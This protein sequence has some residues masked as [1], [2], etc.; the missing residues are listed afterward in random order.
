MR[1]HVYKAEAFVAAVR[2]A[3]DQAN[4]PLVQVGEGVQRLQDH[5]HGGGVL[6]VLDDH[7]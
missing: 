1:V 2:F 6:Q 5:L 3:A 7:C 4:V